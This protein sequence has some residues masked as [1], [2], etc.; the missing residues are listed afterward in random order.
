MCPLAADG[1]AAH[2]GPRLK[3]R[4]GP[5]TNPEKHNCRTRWTMVDW[6]LFTPSDFEYDFERD[7]LAQHGV[8]SMKLLSASFLTFRFAGT[9]GS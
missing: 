9:E 2:D 1:P 6:H 4:V 5:T 8:R 7:E 3:R